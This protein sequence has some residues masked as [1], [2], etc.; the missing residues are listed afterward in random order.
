MWNVYRPSSGVLMKRISIILFLLFLLAGCSAP[1]PMPE[2]TDPPPTQPQLSEVST[3]VATEPETT[4]TMPAE[5]PLGDSFFSAD[6][7][8]PVTVADPDLTQL[9]ENL[10]LLPR[11]SQVRLTGVLPDTRELIRLKEAFPAI[12]FIW[13]FDFLGVPVT[14]LTQSIDLSGTPLADTAELDALLPCFYQLEQV[15]LCDCG[16]S[17]DVM[18]A[19]NERYP[20]TDFIWKVKIGK[21]T[22]RTDA[23]Y[24]M[25]SKY[26]VPWMR[27][28]QTVNL[29]YL[30]KLQFLDLGHYVGISDL[31]FLHHMPDLK[32]LSLNSST[33]SDLSPI[34]SC[35][36]LEFLELFLATGTDLWPL[37]NCT[38]LKNLNISYMPYWDP[39]PIHQM[40]WLDR[41]WVA[42]SKLSQ[43]ERAALQEALPHTIM[44][45]RSDSST[46]KGWRYSPNYYEGR[47]LTQMKYMIK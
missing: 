36:K 7:D 46:D 40:T 17:D 1:V 42:G 10:P 43:E 9:F 19:L 21:L 13:E 2:Q 23:L 6:Y 8:Q 12:T 25:P 14:S 35:Q 30:T 16:L 3:E 33:A 11:I 38:S 32:I 44:V 26:H 15:D 22:T 18:G 34:A 5:I 28:E 37:T 47:D 27:Q 31:S 41:L 39:L 24:F 29:K 45:F 20:D 4:P